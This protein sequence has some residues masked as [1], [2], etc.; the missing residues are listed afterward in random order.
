[1]RTGDHADAARGVFDE[2]ARDG[3]ATGMERRHLR[4]AERLL[5]RVSL[6][7]ESRV[8]DVGCGLGWLAKLLATR[9]R[10]GAFV[11]IDPSLEM[12]LEARRACSGLEQTMFAPGSA[13][14]I[15][16][17]EDYFT[18]VLSI[19]SAYYWSSTEL[20]AREI[21][22]VTAY[23]GAFHILINYYSENPYSEGWGR[24]MDLELR[25]LGADD[26]EALFRRVGFQQVS[27]E[28]IPDDSP[29]LPAGKTA[30]ELARR[31]GL[32][33]TGALH[34]TGTKPALAGPR[35]PSPRPA[36]NPFRVLR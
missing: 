20:A 30:E 19:E 2:W 12:V 16:W 28:R 21:Y 29:I 27:S 26:W 3:T 11:G 8:L 18:H 15:P 31:K 22:R 10:K 1:M 24:A 4:L 5:E 6:S 23:G 32:Q 7:P 36:L 33:R 34:V 13:E 25:R 17:A 35:T 14:A 9:I